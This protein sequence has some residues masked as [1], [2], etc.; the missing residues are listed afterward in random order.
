MTIKQLKSRIKQ[1]SASLERERRKN[2]EIIDRVGWGSG[3]RKVRIGPSYRR[4]NE[5]ENKLNEYKN[6]LEKMEA[7]YE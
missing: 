7:K 4:E 5:L 6:I 3:M 1:I 2:I